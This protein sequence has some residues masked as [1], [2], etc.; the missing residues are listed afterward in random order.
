MYTTY[1]N[2]E[3]K[4]FENTPDPDFFYLSPEH[5]EAL[6]RFAYLLGER[7]GA[8]LL[9][10]E[11]GCGKT[12]M[13]RV[14]GER[15]DL[16]QHRVA[17]LNYPRFSPDALLGEIL[18]QLGADASGDNVARMHRL[19]EIFYRTSEEGGHTIIIVDEA[20]I[21][22]EGGV[23]E[24][25][26]LLLNF[27]LADAFLVTFL[28]VGQPELRERIMRLPPLDQRIAV[29]YHLHNFDLDN[30]RAYIAFRLDVAGADRELFTEDAVEAIYARTFGT[31]RRI[32]NVC[33]LCLFMGSRR[34]VELITDEIVQLVA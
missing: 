14:L 33:D 11:Y 2:L 23:L 6:D 16:E 15:L 4:P 22:P 7:K 24:E 1:W 32:N 28:L 3:R 5:A 10:G 25:L 12:T 9:T 26:R 8:G 34:K 29:R 21:L 20:Q 30:T 27:Q 13:V 31:P 18:Y 19:G 17:Y